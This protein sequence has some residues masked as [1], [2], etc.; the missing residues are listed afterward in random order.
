MHIDCPQVSPACFRGPLWGAVTHLLRPQVWPCLSGANPC[1]CRY[2]Q[3]RSYLRKGGLTIWP[4]GVQLPPKVWA[5]LTTPQEK[6]FRAFDAPVPHH[7]THLLCWGQG[8]VEWT[9]SRGVADCQAASSVVSP[10]EATPPPPP[11][12]EGP[13]CLRDAVLFWSCIRHHSPKVLCRFCI[14]KA[15]KWNGHQARPQHFWVLLPWWC[16]GLG[17]VCAPPSPFWHAVAGRKVRRKAPFMQPSFR[18]KMD[19]QAPPPR[20]LTH[21]VPPNSRSFS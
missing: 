21:A 9:P 16:A 11:L 3:F 5:P 4:F 19:M 10:D 15:K 6:A 8:K 7:M 13:A 12:C 17:K 1:C 14:L 18:H 20:S 2:T